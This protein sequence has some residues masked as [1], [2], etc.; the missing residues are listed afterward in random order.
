L[1]EFGGAIREG[2]IY[3]P[4]EGIFLTK[5]SPLISDFIRAEECS[6]R[7][8]PFYLNDKELDKA[9]ANS[10]KIT[11]IQRDSKSYLIPSKRL[12]EDEITATLF[13][14]VAKKYG[15]YLEDKGIEDMS[16]NFS[17]SPENLDK[18]NRPFAT[19]LYLNAIFYREYTYDD[20]TH[21]VD[22]MIIHDYN[23]KITDGICP[24]GIFVSR[25][26]EGRKKKIYGEILR[27]FRAGTLSPNRL[28]SV[29]RY[30]EN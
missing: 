2:F 24:Q 3:V 21:E 28:D 26:S 20:E 29:L 16:V 25:L 17:V 7:N 11:R 14:K 27:K 9:L 5:V 30:L 1:E 15:R 8:E 6:K 22:K 19:Q 13:G 12:G 4:R 23:S 10:T 18:R